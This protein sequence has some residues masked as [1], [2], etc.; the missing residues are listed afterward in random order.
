[1]RF[2]ER[3]N[4]KMLLSW[5]PECDESLLPIVSPDVGVVLF[6]MASTV[7]ITCSV[8]N[9]REDAQ[10]VKEVEVKE[11]N[12][13]YLS[14]LSKKLSIL[15]SDVNT[16]LTEWVEKEKAVVGV[17]GRSGS[18][19]LE[20]EGIT[21]QLILPSCIILYVCALSAEDSEETESDLKRQKIL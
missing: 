11:D 2:G 16:V 14:E 21:H 5:L 7:S 8:H 17:A 13:E 9:A 19:D 18:S 3:V 4:Q 20:L 10:I 12:T 15:Q 6:K 1:M